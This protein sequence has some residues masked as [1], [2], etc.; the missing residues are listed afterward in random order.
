MG[1][2]R[3]D[4]DPP[5][6]TRP[7]QVVAERIDKEHPKRPLPPVK[8]TAD[9]IDEAI[10]TLLSF[11]SE[12]PPIVSVYWSVSED[13]GQLK[14]GTSKLHDVAKV[15]REYAESKDLS[16][17]AR[18]SLRADAER[19]LEFGEL[20][21][22]M[23]GRTLAL[24]RCSDRD[25]EE[26]TILPGWVRD[27]VEIDA[28]AHLRPLLAVADESH[29]Y[30]VVVVDRKHGRIFEFYLGEL[31]AKEKKDGRALRKPNFAHGDKEHGVRNRAEELAKLHY[32]RTAEA[33]G[34]FV[35][36]QRIELVVVGGH[37][38]TVPAFLDLVEHDLRRMIVGTFVSDLH[39][40]TPAMARD[41]AQQVVD[42]FERR[43]ERD[44]V[45]RVR[46][47]AATGHLGALGLDWCLAAIGAQAVEHLLVDANASAPG[48]VCDSCGRLALEG[49]PCP[50]DGSPT[51]Q[52]PDVI[53]DGA[54]RV[55][56]TRGHVEHVWA[57]TP[58][59]DHTVAALLRF[60]V[61]RPEG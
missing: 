39:R 49:G 33:L 31:E 8:L 45:E 60:P 32:R 35:H 38:D 14:A 55:L 40:L 53:D 50:I 30:A 29:R 1:S 5:P 37:K 18:T 26:A 2:K 23:Q 16:H 12:D 9:T 61:A 36:E 4:R 44:L 27:R 20:V 47:R 41:Q 7:A 59:R 52:T 25:F 13:V 19:I 46:E 10:R 28:T 58:L 15:V 57:E 21:P 17:R 34:H 42:D 48:W 24:F 6:A 56:D 11:R 22:T 3:P 43:E 51:R 54:A